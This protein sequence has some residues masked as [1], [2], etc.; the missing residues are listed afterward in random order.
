MELL[1]GA[2]SANP[3]L[4]NFC[5]TL[6]LHLTRYTVYSVSQPQTQDNSGLYTYVLVLYQFSIFLFL[7]LIF[8]PI[9]LP[10]FH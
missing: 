5:V 1:L 7:V 2:T 8:Y 4:G 3:N 6:M 9:K 10:A